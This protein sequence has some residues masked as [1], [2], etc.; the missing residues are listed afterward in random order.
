MLRWSQI[1]SPKGKICQ[2]NFNRVNN[3]DKTTVLFS[4]TRKHNNLIINKHL[5]VHGR[6][7]VCINECVY[8]C[9]PV[10][11]QFCTILHELF[12]NNTI[13]TVM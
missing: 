13:S 1:N 7:Y 10:K 6:V 4:H 2:F 3:E 11:L 12:L 8:L 9:A 5:V